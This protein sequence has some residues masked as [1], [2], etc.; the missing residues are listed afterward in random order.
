MVEQRDFF[1]ARTIAPLRLRPRRDLASALRSKVTL[2]LRLSLA[3]VFFW[4]G[5]L[6]LAGVSPV[7]DL[8]RHSIPFLAVTPYIELLGLAE[9]V[10]AVGLVIDRLANQAA[11][12]M[13]LHL[14]CTLS[15]AIIAPTLIF[16][17]AFPVL[18]MDGEFLAKNF[19]LITA[20]LVVISSRDR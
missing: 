20:G 17:P 1:T 14:F 2:L 5:M 12:L 7:A 10:I 9:I 11:T 4:F 6:K 18:T 16:A 3:A 13:I 19:V 15:I 8:L